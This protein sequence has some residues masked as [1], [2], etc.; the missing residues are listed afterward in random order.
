[1]H[2]GAS[3]PD[4]YNNAKSSPGIQL[5]DSLKRKAHT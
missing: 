1:M 5:Q 4:T 2:L 3:V